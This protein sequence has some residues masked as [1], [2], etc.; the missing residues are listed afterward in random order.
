MRKLLKKQGY[1]LDEIVTDK[2]GSYSAVLRVL[3]LLHLDVTGRRLNNRAEVSHPLAGSGLFA[4]REM[5]PN[6][7]VQVAG[8]MQRFLSVHNAIYNH[9]NHSWQGMFT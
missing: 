5:T 4:N 7:K 2:L 6:G 1:V 3:G 8:P 9:F